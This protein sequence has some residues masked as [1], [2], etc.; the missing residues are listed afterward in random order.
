MT[1]RIGRGVVMLAISAATAFFVGINPVSA[2]AND[3]SW[4]SDS[5]HSWT[6]DAP[7]SPT[8]TAS[9]SASATPTAASTTT[10]PTPTAAASTTAPA[11]GGT[12]TAPTAASTTAAPTA[13]STTAAPTAAS[14][15]AAPT[16][17]AAASTTAAPTAASAPSYGAPHDYKWDS[18]K[19]DKSWE[20]AKKD[21]RSWSE[22]KS[23]PA[24]SH[25]VDAGGGG[26]APSFP[27][28][29]VAGAGLGA[30][31]LGAGL[32]A[33]RRNRATQ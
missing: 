20:G 8:A 10:A 14:T 12:I 21:D 6:I 3:D 19:D 17:T 7:D 28:T 13:A 18:K 32:T 4:D 16:P 11:W 5:H 31:M 1:H 2:F 15:T 26:T 29:P 24:P 23:Y 25:G 33:R 22:A 30:A 27:I 9:A